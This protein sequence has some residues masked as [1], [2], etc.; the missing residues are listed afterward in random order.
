MYLLSI[1]NNKNTRIDM[2]LL[3]AQKNSNFEIV[4]KSNPHNGY[5]WYLSTDPLNTKIVTFI[6]EIKKPLPNYMGCKQHF[7]FLTRGVGNQ[8]LLFIY[9]RSWEDTNYDEKRFKVLVE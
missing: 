4:L 8:E 9:K 1:T 2:E 6:E 5:L 3:K 7:N